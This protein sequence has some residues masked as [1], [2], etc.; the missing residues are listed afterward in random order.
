M[1]PKYESGAMKRKRKRNEQLLTQSQACAMDKYFKS[2]NVNELNE[3]EDKEV[4]KHS[5]VNEVAHFF[6]ECE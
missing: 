6:F 2:S 5:C 3:D 1:P 4:T